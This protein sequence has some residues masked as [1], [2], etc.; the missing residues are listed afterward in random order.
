MDGLGSESRLAAAGPWKL[1]GQ[2]RL[3]VP[4]LSLASIAWLVFFKRH[5]TNLP[6]YFALVIGGNLQVT[7]SLRGT[8]PVPRKEILS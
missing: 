7:K 1:W 2:A 4:V 8:P 6:T 3:P 5:T